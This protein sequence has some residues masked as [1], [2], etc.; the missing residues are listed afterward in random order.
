MARRGLSFTH[1][2]M[3]TLA[4][5]MGSGPASILS[6]TAA[7]KSSSSRARELELAVYHSP[8]FVAGRVPMVMRGKL[9]RGQAKLVRG[10]LVMRARLV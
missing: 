2:A 8:A 9:V 1:G 3:M 6:G 5:A 7:R 10:K 4:P